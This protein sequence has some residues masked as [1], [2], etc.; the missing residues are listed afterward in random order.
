MGDERGWRGDWV[1][2]RLDALVDLVV[3]FRPVRDPAAGHAQ[4][5]EVPGVFA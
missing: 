5:D 4:V 2:G 3:H 1:E